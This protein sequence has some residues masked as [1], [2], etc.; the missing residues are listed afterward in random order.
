[1]RAAFVTARKITVSPKLKRLLN[2]AASHGVV[3]GGMD[4]TFNDAFRARDHGLVEM[5]PNNPRVYT[6]TEKGR[7]ALKDGSYVV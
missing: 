3:P 2:G 1:M 4:A 7:T 5:S 6:I